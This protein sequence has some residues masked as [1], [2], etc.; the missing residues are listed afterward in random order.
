MPQTMAIEGDTPTTIY[1]R[2]VV[3]V[4]LIKIGVHGTFFAYN[5]SYTNA[6]RTTERTVLHSIGTLFRDA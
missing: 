5:T 4:Y 3:G 2:P 6:Y 1:W